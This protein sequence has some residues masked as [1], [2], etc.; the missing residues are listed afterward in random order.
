MS[1]CVCVSV[2]ACQCV[3]VC[4]CVCVPYLCLT[5]RQPVDGGC[6]FSF[7]EEFIENS[8][9]LFFNRFVLHFRL[10]GGVVIHLITSHMPLSDGMSVG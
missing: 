9:S 3:C 1:V 4:V 5:E 8:S 7:P 10:H 2:C 6:G